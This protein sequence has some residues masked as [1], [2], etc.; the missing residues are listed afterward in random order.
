MFLLLTA[1]AVVAAVLVAKGEN[2][3]PSQTPDVDPSTLPCHVTRA[4]GPYRICLW[5]ENKGGSTVWHWRAE[6]APGK[7]LPAGSPA[8]I[9]DLTD[10]D[11]EDDALAAAWKRL[12]E[13]GAILATPQTT[14]RHGVRLEPNGDAF[15]DDQAAYVNA[16][17]PVI[18]SETMKGETGLG[19]V[20]AVL[21]HIFPNVN[22]LRIRPTTGSLE[23][24]AQRVTNVGN[25]NPPAIARAIF[26][27]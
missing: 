9:V 21:L 14:T 5:R 1:L 27:I 12:A 16:V 8:S 25:G 19:L 4:D 26:G 2:G 10:F 6:L 15:V 24:A 11:S 22:P 3:E 20:L 23:L 7:T 18:S 17:S 13:H